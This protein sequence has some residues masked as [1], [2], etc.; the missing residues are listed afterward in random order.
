[1]RAKKSHSL[2]EDTDSLRDFEGDFEGLSVSYEIR[3]PKRTWWLDA[4]TL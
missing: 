4:Y 2:V 3:T 1:M